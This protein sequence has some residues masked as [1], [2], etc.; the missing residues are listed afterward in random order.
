MLTLSKATTVFH[1]DA[2]LGWTSLI[3]EAEQNLELFR[4]SKQLGFSL[5]QHKSMCFCFSRW[6]WERRRGCEGKGRRGDSPVSY[7]LQ[8]KQLLM[9]LQKMFYFSSTDV[10]IRKFT[11][12]YLFS[13]FST[14]TRTFF[15]FFCRFRIRKWTVIGLN[16]YLKIVK[17]IKIN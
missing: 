6:K 4:V 7:Y 15:F 11:A 5:D 12:S 1:W 2:S 3:R 8:R 14:A 13:W 9:L 16:N 10:K 17:M